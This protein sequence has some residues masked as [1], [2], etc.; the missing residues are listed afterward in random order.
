MKV[1]TFAF[2]IALAFVSTTSW[3][4][5]RE[6]PEQSDLLVQKNP[7]Q[8]A[9]AVFHAGKVQFLAVQGYATETPGAPGVSYCWLDA[10]LATVLDGTTDIIC[11][12]TQENFKK[13]ARSFATRFNKHLFELS[14]QLK[15][16]MCAN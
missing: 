3:S 4:C 16:H 12:Q 9:E 2:I 8:E 11:N 7:E 13:A 1:L 10:G 15:K 5:E 6:I 14:A